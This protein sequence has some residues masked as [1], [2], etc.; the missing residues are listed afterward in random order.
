MFGDY[1]NNCNK[2]ENIPNHENSKRKS[3]CKQN[4]FKL[5]SYLLPSLVEEF[6]NFIY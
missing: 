5:G 6:G 1:L 2:Q 4:M 3:K